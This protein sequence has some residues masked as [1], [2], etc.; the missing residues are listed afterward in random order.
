M[1]TPQITLTATLDTISG[2][3]AGSVSNPARL[4]IA[5]C[6]YG[7]TLPTIPGTANIALVGPFEYYSTGGL[8]TIL[9]WGNDAISPAGTFYEIA[10]IDG[11]LN[12]VQCG[13]YQFTGTETIDLSSAPQLVPTNFLEYAVCSGAIPGTVYVAPG[14]IVA[15]YY[16]GLALR[17]SIDWNASAP[18]RATLTFTTTPRDTIY[19]LCT[20][21]IPSG[22]IPNANS[23]QFAVCT[24]AIPGTAYV[25][26][27]QVVGVAYNGNFLRSGID[28]TV[29]TL[30]DITLNFSTGLGDTIYALCF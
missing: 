16:N 13:A 6:G 11:E 10:V 25:A 12:V 30:V 5:L 28:Y 20:V 7:Q 3:A 18:N 27:G 24:G 17:K 29:A 1:L 14:V 23:L 21:L 4:R 19:A 8:L 22:P 9:L 2:S 15:L 26:P